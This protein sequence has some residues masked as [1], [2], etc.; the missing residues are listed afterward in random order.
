MTMVPLLTFAIKNKPLPPGKT[1]P[2][3]QVW[4]GGCS[5]ERDART[6]TRRY[7]LAFFVARREAIELACLVFHTVSCCAGAYTMIVRLSNASQQLALVSLLG[8]CASA[9]EA[10]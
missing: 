8:T 4:S 7:G 2:P 1:K 10:E 3:D 9:G 6:L 5:S